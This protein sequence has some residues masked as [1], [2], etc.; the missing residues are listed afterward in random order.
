MKV[1]PLGDRIIVEAENPDEVTKG[2]IIIPKTATKEMP[3]KGE[4]IAIGPGARNE[5][6]KVIPMRLKIGDKIMY[7]KYAGTEFKI[8][9]QKFLVMREDDVIGR[10]VPSSDKEK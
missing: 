3:Q 8:G 9:E 4:I 10:I 7:N 1:E 5:E 6:G 2:G